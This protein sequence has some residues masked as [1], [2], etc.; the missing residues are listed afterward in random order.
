LK[1]VCKFT[2]SIKSYNCIFF[3]R[4]VKEM[5]KIG[6]QGRLWLRSFHIFFMAL[7]IGAVFSQT[8]IILFTGKAQSDGGLQAMYV[9]PDILNAVTG[10]GFLGT[11]ITGILL[12]WLTPWGFFKHKWVM[13]TMA[14]VALDLLLGQIVG[15]S[16]GSK[17]AALA[18]TEG[19]S[20]LQNPEYISAWYRIIIVGFVCSLLLISAAFVSVL[21]PWRKRTEAEAAT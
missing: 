10:P 16:A 1:Q 18:G 7:W 14:M 5:R 9:I 20:A 12:S 8:I 3:F 21:K 13:Y 6:R 2:E 11:L 15:G 19:L 17:L 4:E